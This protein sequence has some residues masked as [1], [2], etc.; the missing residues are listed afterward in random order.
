MS[1]TSHPCMHQE[2]VV[3]IEVHRHARVGGQHS[4]R[5]A[6]PLGNVGSACAQFPLGKK[7]AGIWEPTVAATAILPTEYVGAVMELFQDRRGSLTEHTHLGPART[8]LRS[9]GTPSVAHAH[10]CFSEGW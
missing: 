5:P 3:S 1:D 8:L 7:L 4:S 10:A 6:W 9:E 2:S